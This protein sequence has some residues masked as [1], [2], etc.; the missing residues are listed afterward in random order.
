MEAMRAA[1]IDMKPVHSRFV[2]RRKG[3]RYNDNTDT[4]S[5]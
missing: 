4:D 1:N 3:N 2:S 5:P